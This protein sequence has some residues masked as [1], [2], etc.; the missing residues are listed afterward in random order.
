MCSL[1]YFFKTLVDS[2]R[3]VYQTNYE[4]I[5]SPL[6]Q[7]KKKRVQRSKW[8][9]NGGRCH[10]EIWLEFHLFSRLFC[11]LFHSWPAVVV[12]FQHMSEQIVWNSAWL[13]CSHGRPVGGKRVSEGNKTTR[14]KTKRKRRRKIT[15]NTSRDRRAEW[16]RECQGSSLAA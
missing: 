15:S 5:C 11:R 12:V 13:S 4:F 3:E 6:K 2:L 9:T 10:F 14:P 1:F 16:E 7:E 8:K